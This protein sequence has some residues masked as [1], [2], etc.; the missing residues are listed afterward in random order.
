MCITEGNRICESS[1]HNNKFC[2]AL[3]EHTHAHTPVQV[4]SSYLSWL[5]IKCLHGASHI[6]SR[7]F[8]YYS[9]LY[10]TVIVCL[11]VNVN[12]TFIFIFRVIRAAALNYCYYYYY[13]YYAGR[14]RFA[15]IRSR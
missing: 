9:R 12:F 14:A 7:S 10:N 5:N 1:I 6:P 13:D 11:F 3:L 8:V 15:Q 2:V 4:L